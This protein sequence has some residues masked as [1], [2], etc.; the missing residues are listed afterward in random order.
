MELIRVIILGIVQGIAEFLPISSSAHLILTRYLFNYEEA[1]V[2]F[3]VALHF[4]TLIAILAVFY[5]D[6]IMYAKAVL[7]KIF[8]KQDSKEN[9]IFWYLVIATIPAGILGL[10][11]ESYIE[12]KIR[13]NIL[14][15]AIV[16]GVVGIIIY[17]TDKY[18]TNK[19]SNPTDME[20]ITLKQS[21]IIGIMQCTA[22]VPGVSRSGAT[23]STGRLLGLSREAA[24]KFSFLLSTPIIFAATLFKLKEL[25]LYFDMYLVI[26]VITSA[27]V[28]FITIKFLLEYIKTKSFEIFAYYRLIFAIIVLIK[29][30]II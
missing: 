20:K 14:L 24:A 12:E 8:K 26:G 2:A 3:D 23:I 10:L 28:G 6:W 7:N 4:G 29:L 5:K 30:L 21:I 11:F 9:N 15:I 25:I 17:L 16:L 27:I 22:M 13:G 18:A 1:S 19:Y